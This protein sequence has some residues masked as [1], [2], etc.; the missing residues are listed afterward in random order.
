MSA[1]L[2]SPR[3]T[4]PRNTLLCRLGRCPVRKCDRPLLPGKRTRF[5]V[6][7][8]EKG[9]V[10]VWICVACKIGHTRAAQVSAGNTTRRNKV[11]CVAAVMLVVCLLLVHLMCMRCRPPSDSSA[12]HSPTQAQLEAAPAAA[13]ASY[14]A[15]IVN[16]IKAHLCVCI[17]RILVATCFLD[18]TC[19]ILANPTCGGPQLLPDTRRHGDSVLA[20]EQATYEGRSAGPTRVG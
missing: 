16:M 15:Q 19:R 10:Q 17:K 8:P 3:R 2:A 7:D 14:H 11:I 12:F 5:D 13:T 6:A 20:T 4:V 1:V 18:V 9:H